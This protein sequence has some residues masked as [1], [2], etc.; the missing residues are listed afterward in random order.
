MP[1]PIMLMGCSSDAGKSFLVTALCRH[2]ANRGRRV[3]PFKAQNMS[4]NAAV[5]PDGA[6]I[7]RAQYLQ[8]LAARV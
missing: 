8:A 7:G 2:L 3:A 4:N 5:T 6:E 1:P